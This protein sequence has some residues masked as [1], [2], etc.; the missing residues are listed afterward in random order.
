[1]NFVVKAFISEGISHGNYS[2]LRVSA[3]WKVLI[4]LRQIKPC[5]DLP[6]Y[7]KIHRI[8]LILGYKLLLFLFVFKIVCGVSDD[9]QFCINL[10]IYF[11]NMFLPIRKIGKPHCTISIMVHLLSFPMQSNSALIFL[12]AFPIWTRSISLKIYRM[13]TPCHN[14]NR[15]KSMYLNSWT[16]GNILTVHNVFD[17]LLEHIHTRICLKVSDALGASKSSSNMLQSV[18][19]ATL[20]PQ[21]LSGNCRH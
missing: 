9:L 10:K 20:I 12:K 1:M 16:W 2:K 6:T 5:Y 18:G 13:L 14:F 4:A 17:S 19:R 3:S 8:W 15:I 21:A 7:L 11:S